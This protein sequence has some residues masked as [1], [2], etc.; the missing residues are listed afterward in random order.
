MRRALWIV[1]ILTAQG[2]FAQETPPAQN[3]SEETRAAQGQSQAQAAPKPGHP[4]D[5]A[6]VDVLTGKTKPSGAPG[7][8]YGVAPSPYASYPVNVA[9]YVPGR[10]LGSNS[11]VSP[12]FT[13]LL[14]GRVRGRSFFLTGNTTGFSRSLF[15][16]SRGRTGSS[17]FFF[18][19]AH[20]GF[21]LPP[22][23]TLPTG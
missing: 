11:L 5:P 3:R 18:T 23:K 9:G 19:P 13:P 15:F 22:L 6:D 21:F 12:P 10:A 2:V 7:Y 16:F 20:P 14:F 4:L 1:M 8:R 17:T